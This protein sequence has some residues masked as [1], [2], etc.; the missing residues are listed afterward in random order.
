MSIIGKIEGERMAALAY[1]NRVLLRAAE[2]D[3]QSASLA[4]LEDIKHRLEAAAPCRNESALRAVLPALRGAT[5]RLSAV[6]DVMKT[7][8]DFSD[9]MPGLLTRATA[10]AGCVGRLSGP[11]SGTAD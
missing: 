9:R 4:E 5:S 8:H 1:V 11:A 10:V 6:A 2:L 3:W 7:S